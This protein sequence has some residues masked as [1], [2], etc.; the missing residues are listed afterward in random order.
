MGR[1]SRSTIAAM[2]LL[3]FIVYVTD[4]QIDW[5][6]FVVPIATETVVL[7][8]PYQASQSLV[9]YVEP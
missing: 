8:H 3:N 5:P 4:G 2:C 9:S 1:M 6:V 7:L